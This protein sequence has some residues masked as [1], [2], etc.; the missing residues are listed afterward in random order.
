[1]KTEDKLREYLKRAT[2][3]LR[4]AR[5]QIQHLETAAT[6]PLAIVGMSCRFP[7]DVRSPEDFWQLLER[8]GDAL[9][10]FPD[11]R[12]WPLESLFDDDP[13]QAGKSYVS[14]GGFVDTATQFDAELFGISPREALA[15]DPQQ[16]L[17]LEGA[18]EA[19]ERTGIDPLKLHGT[20][21]GVFVGASPSGY[22]SGAR[23][24]AEIEGYTLT[25]GA[26]SVLS[27][28]ISYTFGLEGPAVTADTACSSSLVAL[29]LAGQSLR[30]GECSLA[31]A[32]GVMVLASPGLF[33]G[34]S[35]QR[36]LAADGR[37]K[38]FA[39]AA[40][41][42]G[43]SEGFGV[44]VVERLADAVRNG[45]RILAVVRGSAVNQDGASNG[46][47]APNGPSQRRVIRAALADAGVSARQVDAVEA[48][49]TGTTLGDPIE[50]QALLA[51]YGQDRDADKPLWLGSVKSNIGHTATAAGMA[52]VI[53]MVLALQHG[54]LPKTLHVDA[55][56]PHIDWSSGAVRLLTEARDWRP[57]DEPRRAAV[58]AFGISG[59]NAHLILEEPPR[60]DTAAPDAE[61]QPAEPAEPAE[62]VEPAG[63]FEPHWRTPVV[64]W[65]VAAKSPAAL[66]AQARRLADFADARPDV[67]PATLGAALTHTRAALDRRAVVVAADRADLVAGLH[68]IAEDAPAPQNVS[69][70]VA[71]SGRI[72]FVF[73]GQGAQWD[74]MARELL[75][76][77]RVFAAKIAECEAAFADLVDWSLT[78]IL[79]GA[80][81]AP[82]LDRVDVVQ[83]VS[84]A[85]M[86]SLAALWR[87]HGV[88]PS[89]VVGHSQGEIAAAHVAGALSLADA[90]RIVVLRSA[91]IVKLAG[92]GTMASVGEERTALEARLAHWNGR[93]SLAAANGP[94]SSVVAGD[95]E[96]VTKLI[97][98]CEADGLRAR[99]IAVD[100]AS[101]SAHV[102]T[103]REELASSLAG[104]TAHGAPL[105][106]CSTVT[107]EPVDTTTLDADYWY[108]N[109][110]QPVE[111]ET[112]TRR[113]LDLGYGTF[114]EVSTHPVLRLGLTQTLEDAG[115]QAVTIG[116]LQR[117]DGGPDRFLKSLAQAHVHGVPVDWTPVLP[118][119]PTDLDLPTYPFQREQYWLEPA[120]PD[121]GDLTALGLGE[122][123]HPLLGAL[124]QVADEDTVV[125]TGRLSLRTQPW[126][127]G[128]AVNGS[129]LLPGAAFVELAVRAG[130]EVGCE[131][132]HELALEVPLTLDE[133][134]EVELQVR[135]APPDGAGSRPVTVQSR[136]ATGDVRPWTRHASGLLTDVA[137]TE[138]VGQGT[139]WPPAGAESVS[140]EGFYER[141]AGAGYEYG[142]AFRGL[143]AAWRRGDE[144][145]A[146]V[147]LPEDVRTEAAAYGIHPALLDSVLHAGLLELTEDDAPQREAHL[148]FVWN[149]V[150]LFA[151]G[152]TVLR[153]RATTQQDGTLAV[154]AT[155]PAGNPV[156]AVDGIL[157]RPV[158]SAG[159]AATGP[160][161]ADS[162]FRVEWT[163]LDRDRLPVGVPL[164]SDVAVIAPEGSEL[165]SGFHGVQVH[166]D[167]GSLVGVVD[168]GGVV[169][170]VVLVVV[171]G[172][173]GV[174]GVGSGGLV[175]GGVVS[176]VVSGVLGLVQGWL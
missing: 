65:L 112:A 107:G 45:R 151:G 91:A 85:V 55:P 38:A 61:S 69:G 131:R 53:K 153:V 170:S 104:V 145:F 30:R 100:Y 138:P 59:T 40:D 160:A 57:G 94:R 154:S 108:R 37:A 162:L 123:G 141:L 49:G 46:L 90:A 98:E 47:T 62:S 71:K 79:N 12:G 36:G 58:S 101:H 125:L 128:H 150:T 14:E 86:V 114:I 7:G 10:K 4:Q 82:D 20:R 18:W 163:A 24:P 28:R 60:A 33:L 25:G 5:R 140:L 175:G 129:V 54:T 109:L 75:T 78:D 174:G 124:V 83:P 159:P 80:E 52:G 148:P 41:G 67:A 117:D 157:S 176:G 16:R 136:P 144:V 34:F 149:G 134:T 146:E 50:A 1:M 3:D 121:A 48:H 66:R 39:A 139:V 13:D 73:P 23:L 132:L 127:A 147:E 9:T 63:S 6:Q 137:P 88:E 116:T 166:R 161:V 99:R 81:G 105:L 35:R 74:G 115:S 15:M 31:V 111:F 64:P 17:L 19:F 110:R 77:S 113:L 152:A 89:G 87:A 167:L 172:V 72:A 102:E 32:A 22:G 95:T 158:A 21:T 27:G 42:T 171:G 155:D 164:D 68:A 173:G 76:T 156:V 119:P 106:L 2:T 44:L 93:I 143:R 165:L 168:G 51:T 135:V 120:A 26:V 133:R 92:E 97:A 84:F 126:L 130:D 96:A 29:H 43:L 122:A 8:G 103:I 11:D 142:S 70:Q 56:S 169:P 118:A